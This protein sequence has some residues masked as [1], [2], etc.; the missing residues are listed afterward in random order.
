MRGVIG[1]PATGLAG[2]VAWATNFGDTNTLTSP[3]NPSFTASAATNTNGYGVFSTLLP[4][5]GQYYIDVNL[6]QGIDT[7][8]VG[9][10]GIANEVSQFPYSSTSKYKAWYYSGAWWGDSG[11][12]SAGDG[13]LASGTYRIAV[14]RTGNVFY[15]QRT[16]NTPT[17]IRSGNLP[18]G[19]NMYLMMLPQSGYAAIGCTILNGGAIAGHG[20][21]Y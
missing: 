2:N 14:N 1:K 19:S 3:P 12:I 5:T 17:A 7:G 4:A 6:L 11:T 10:F 16:T 18:S 21:L 8:Q 9:F 15:M 13:S 20:G